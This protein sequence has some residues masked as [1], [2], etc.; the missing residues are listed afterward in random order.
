[1]EVLESIK[2]RLRVDDVSNDVND[3]KLFILLG[4]HFRLGRVRGVECS[5]FF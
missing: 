3:T 4:R 1:M 2:F 5:F